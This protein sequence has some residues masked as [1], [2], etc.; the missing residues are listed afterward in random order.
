MTVAGVILFFIALL[1]GG[2]GWVVRE[3]AARQAKVAHDLELALDR[4]DLFQG[5]GKRAEA[6]AALDRAELLG[7]QAS[8]HQARDQRLTALRARLDAEKRDTEFLAG[9]EGIRLRAQSQVNVEESRFASEAA[10]PEIQEALRHYGIAVGAVPPAE[11][12][13]RI[14]G[15]PEAVRRQLL[16][17]LDECLHWAPQGDLQT[18]QWLLATLEAV[19]ADPWRVQVRKALANRDWMTLKPLARDVDVRRQS[20]SFLLVVANSLPTEIKSIRLELLRRIQREWPADLWANHGLAFELWTNNQPAEAIRYFTAALALRPDSPGMYV[21]LGLALRD[22]GEVDAAIADYQRALALAPGYAVA[23]NDLGTALKANGRLDEAIAELREAIRLKTD[24]PEAHANLGNALLAK[25]QIDDAIAENRAAFRLNK[26]LPGIQVDLGNALLAK[27]QPD[28]AIAEYRAAI[29][30]NK[31]DANAH[32]NLGNAFM[33]KGRI[34]DAIA[35][36]R[37][38][39]RIKADHAGA[40]SNLGVALRAKNRIDDAIAEFRAA[41]RIKNDLPEAHHGLGYALF[42]KGQLDEAIPE[43]REAIRLKADDANAHYHLGNALM[44]KGRLDDAMAAF[45]E[46]IRLK[47]DHAQAHT[48]LGV[49]L[50]TKNRLDDA[51]AEYRAAIRI[52]NDLPEAHHEL[53]NALFVK[54]H[55][56]EAIAEYRQAIRANNALPEAHY[57][58]G[59]AL[60]AK[61][62]PD[63]AIAELRDA[64][65]LK[66][67]YAEAHCILGNALTAKG[68]LEEAIAM[69]REAIRINTDS[70]EAHCN[71]GRTLQREGELQ[72]A[73]VELRRG[74]ELGSKDPRW[75]Y[76]SAA[77]V[78]QC[79]R[80]VEL[81]RR[82][83]GILAGKATPGSSG[84]RLELAGLCSL[85]RLNGAA[86]RLY[87]EAFAADPKLAEDPSSSN[88][89]NAACAAALAGCG[90]GVNAD[91]IDASARGRL[92]H[93]ALDW[94]RADRSAWDRLLEKAPDKVRQVIV[95]T[96]QHWL[97]DPDLA[98]VRGPQ[99]LATLSES[100]SRLWQTLWDEV[101]DT[102][103]RAQGKTTPENS[104]GAR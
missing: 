63:E 44:G 12:G 14:L 49:A 43:Y 23:H 98:G 35:G 21:N 46:A 95:Q 75:E 91:K 38:A 3:R 42:E 78:R 83:P 101:A 17:A 50:S 20:P 28:E 74:H 48:N 89:Y 65:R 52:K 99:A 41:I 76:P 31:D 22:A 80:L 4:A 6:L 86:A 66:K 40:H 47:K 33:A 45:Q 18:R 15:R 94:L 39:I 72:A 81:D 60:L 7:S 70:A 104:S 11:A 5:E 68:Q 103:T 30:A 55:L 92:R 9:F 77:W 58:L 73:L 37:E 82:L 34:D 51:I 88:R 16:A 32:F 36:F 56:D 26:D 27:G 61:G 13:A 100:E 90:Q 2:A 71:L 85:K 59:Y 64:I 69:F 8:P 96:L 62:Q 29:R 1:G 93:Q 57:G 53:G 79:E 10:F 24:Y 67:N 87:E 84:E 97:K 25:G 54:G 102:L 19:D